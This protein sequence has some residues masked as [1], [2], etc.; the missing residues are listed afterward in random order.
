ML[1]PLTLIRLSVLMLGYPGYRSRWMQRLGLYSDA[2]LGSPAIWVHAVSV[3]E[4][5]AAVQLIKA[6]KIK[7]PDHRVVIT[8]VTPTGAET[9]VTRFSDQIRH[10]YLPYDLPYA[11]KSFLRHIRPVAGVIMETE[12][13]PN[14]YHHAD[15]TDIPILLVNARISD[16][17]FKGYMRIKRLTRETLCKTKLVA[18]QSILDGERFLALGCEKDKLKV[19]DNLKYDLEVKKDLREQAE[20]LKR[21]YFS[22]RPVWIAAST[23]EG[24]EE[25]A[26]SVHKKLLS[27]NREAVLI[28]APRHPQRF[29]RVHGICMENDFKVTRKSASDRF[30]QEMK[31]FLLDSLGDLPLYYAV[32]NLAFVGGSLVQVGGHNLLEPASVETTIITGPHTFNFKDVVEK[33]RSADALYTVADEAELEEKVLSMFASPERAKL[34]SDNALRVLEENRGGTNQT[35]ELISEHIN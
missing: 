25:L 30:T 4:V 1:L 5:E 8:T 6:I 18:S 9:V 13:W 10:Y 3:G 33:L 15:A 28:I 34:M 32:A 35:L 24:E 2:N 22:G 27:N 20:I 31:V 26:L 14:L 7:Y 11:V 21:D 17:S 29:E 16:A 19:V 23:H 12:I